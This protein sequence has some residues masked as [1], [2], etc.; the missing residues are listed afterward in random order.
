VSDY[1]YATAG[2]GPGDRRRGR[3]RWVPWVLGLVVVLGVVLGVAYPLLAGGKATSVPL[4]DNQPVATA[5]RDILAAHLRSVVVDQANPNVR[6]GYVISS[7]P[8]QGNNVATNTLVTLYVST[9]AAPVAVPNVVGQ[10]ESQAEATLQ[11]KGF[12]VNVKQD[13][14]S[15]QP[16]GTVVSQSPST[17]TAAPGSTVTITVSGGAVSVPSV[18]GDSQQTASQVLTTAGFAVSVQQGSGPSNFANGTVFSQQPNSGSTAAKGST[19]TIFVQN[20]ASPSPTPTTPS[21]S[22]TPSGT[23]PTG[24]GF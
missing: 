7:N 24:V 12:Q 18:I 11:G 22:P 15:P 17:G 10:Q 2:H 21:P 4:V 9:G 14:T 3:Y 1:D 16:A 8:P 23:G 5:Q 6:K 20:G 13:P 19:V